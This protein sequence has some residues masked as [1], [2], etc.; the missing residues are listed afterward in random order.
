MERLIPSGV[1]MIAAIAIC[2]DMTLVTSAIRYF[3]HLVTFIDP[4]TA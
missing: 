3:E 4:R 1:G 2:H